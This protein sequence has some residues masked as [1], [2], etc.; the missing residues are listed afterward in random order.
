MLLHLADVHLVRQDKPDGER[1]EAETDR[2]FDDGD[3]VEQEHFT[4][5]CHCSASASSLPLAQEVA[6]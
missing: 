4:E 2:R 6:T 1:R 5:L 3:S